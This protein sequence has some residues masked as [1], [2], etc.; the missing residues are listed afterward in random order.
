[1]ANSPDRLY[2]EKAD[3]DLYDNDIITKEI[4]YGKT[5]KDQFLFAMAI[6]FKNK[7]KRPLESREGFFLA[8]D[9]HTEDEALIDI[10]AIYDNDSVDLL[11]KRE[12]VFKIAEE[13]AHA[14]IRLLYDEATSGQPGSYF[15][16]LELDLVKL[17]NYIK[18]E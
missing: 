18:V 16:K 2:I 8:K 9:L 10:V 7:V 4:L 17:V 14:G 15:K 13:Y 1:M 6:G 3:R 11:Q 5:R 12:E